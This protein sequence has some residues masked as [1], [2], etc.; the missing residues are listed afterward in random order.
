LSQGLGLYGGGPGSHAPSE[1]ALSEPRQGLSIIQCSLPL[2]GAFESL[3]RTLGIV[4]STTA[5]GF[6]WFRLGGR[7]CCCGKLI[8]RDGYRRQGNQRGRREQRG[9][10]NLPSDLLQ[11]RIR[12]LPQTTTRGTECGQVPVGQTRSFGDIGSTFGLPTRMPRDVPGHGCAGLGAYL[13]NRSAP[14]RVEPEALSSQT[15][16]DPRSSGGSLSH[17]KASRGSRNRTRSSLA[18][19]GSPL[20]R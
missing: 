1:Y 11:T 9:P 19:R 15:Q 16:N 13:I 10:H 4:G 2:S 20:E 8:L 5:L 18:D 12:T 14:S 17:I 7:L 3:A 6:D